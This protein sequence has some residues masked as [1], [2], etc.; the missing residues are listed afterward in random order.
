MGERMSQNIIWSDVDAV[1]PVP[2]HWTRRWNR[3][4]NQ[5]ELLAAALAD[6]LGAS[7]CS[8]VLLRRRRTQ[9]QTKLE[10]GE[11]AGN[12]SGA[13]AVNT[14]AAF[15]ARHILLVDDIFTT[16][17]TLAECFTVLRQSFQ[18][19]VRISIATLGYVI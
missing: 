4:Y 10:L 17:S 14:E 6:S 2:L 8:D 13:F 12:V 11:K 9:T 16:G 15:S 19:E 5:A 1:I 3:G 18:E 7:L